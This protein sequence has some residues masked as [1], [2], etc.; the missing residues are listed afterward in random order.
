[1]KLWTMLYFILFLSVLCPAK[2]RADLNGDCRVDLADLAILA[3]EWLQEDCDM[4]LGPELAVDGG[5]DDGGAYWVTEDAGWS[6]IDGK[7]QWSGLAGALNQDTIPVTAG[8]LYSVSYDISDY[9]G[10]GYI[11]VDVG[12]NSGS[13]ISFDGTHTEQITAGE[14][15]T[16]S[17]EITGSGCS[18][19]LDNISVR[20]IIPDTGG[21]G[22]DFFDELWE[23]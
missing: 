20:E 14:D 10:F 13:L 2:L 12:G 9:S 3:S 11:H 4:A 6:F 17:L 22:M 23:N 19:K 5:F 18:L 16:F 21:I 15:G 8:T 7:A 1:M